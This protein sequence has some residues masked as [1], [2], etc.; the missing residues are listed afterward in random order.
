MKNVY[1]VCGRTVDARK[2]L[3]ES[4]ELDVVAWNS[5]LQ[6]YADS[7]DGEALWELFRCMPDRDVVSWNTVIGF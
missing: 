5:M 6:A 4:S 2:V 1:D 7:R 3:D